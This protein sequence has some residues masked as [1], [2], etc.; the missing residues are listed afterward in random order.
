MPLEI[1]IRLMKLGKKQKD[2]LFELRKRNINTNPPHLSNVLNGV[3]EGKQS[4]LILKMCDEIVSEWE[5]EAIS[6]VS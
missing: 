1:K 6:N 4:Q 5:K 2:L 3:R